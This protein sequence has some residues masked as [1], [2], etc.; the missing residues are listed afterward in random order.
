MAL[1]PQSPRGPITHQLE[2]P[3]ISL[4]LDLLTGSSARPQRHLF[5]RGSQHREEG[6]YR[7]PAPYLAASLTAGEW[8]GH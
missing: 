1:H 5:T 7:V 3:N 6:P 4:Q 2:D 8:G